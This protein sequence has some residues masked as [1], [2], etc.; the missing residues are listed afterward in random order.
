MRCGTSKV[1]EDEQRVGERSKPVTL[2][3]FGDSFACAT[4]EESLFAESH[5]EQSANSYEK[6]EISVIILFTFLSLHIW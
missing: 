4:N 2:T 3:S 6:G 5:E 1:D